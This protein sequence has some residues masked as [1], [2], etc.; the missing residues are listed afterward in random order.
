M[1]ILTVVPRYPNLLLLVPIEE[2]DEI[3]TIFGKEFVCGM[4]QPVL[5]AEKSRCNAD[6]QIVGVM[7]YLDDGHLYAFDTNSVLG[8]LVVVFVLQIFW[9]GYLLVKASVVLTWLFCGA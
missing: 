1:N 2:V 7:C 5:Q 8:P 3:G 4:I 9:Q 6:F